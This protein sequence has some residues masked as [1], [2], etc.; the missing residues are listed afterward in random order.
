M[1]KSIF[2]APVIAIVMAVGAPA[3]AR[4]FAR[5]DYIDVTARKKIPSPVKAGPLA[6]VAR[7]LATMPFLDRRKIAIE[8]LLDR[9]GRRVF[10]VDHVCTSAEACGDDS[11]AASREALDL[12]RDKSGRWAIAWVGLQVKCHKGRGHRAW[13]KAPCT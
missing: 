10:R 2:V 8:V 5:L 3:Y 11:V 7:Y 13:S 1:L 12:R 4:D 6:V 9:D